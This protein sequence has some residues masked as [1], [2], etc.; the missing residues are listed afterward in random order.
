LGKGDGSFLP[1]VRYAAGT[2]PNS[3]AV[4]DFNRDQQPDLAIANDGGVSVLI[5]KSDGSFLPA[6]S[7]GAGRNP[8][9]V[10][11]GDFNADQQLD[12]AVAN[13][14]GISVLL[15][16]GDGSFQPAVTYRAGSS[17]SSV[18]LGD[19]NG[20]G[21]LDVSVANFGSARINFTDSSA[22]VLLG[23]GDG[24][25]QDNTN[26]NAGT[27]PSSVAVADFNGDGKADLAVANE[28]IAVFMGNGDGTFREAVNFA[29]S[30]SPWAVAVGDFNGDGKPDLVGANIDSANVSVLLNT[31]GAP[32]LDLA[33]V[34]NGD[35]LTVSWQ[36]PSTGFVLESIMALDAA[37]WQSAAEMPATNNGRLEVTVPIS[38]RE[39]YFRLHKP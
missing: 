5:G 10:A 15:G 25:F 12:L 2:S 8:S 9:A 20:D 26:F 39:R 24:T 36:F 21:N 14:G 29:V 32:G 4:G 38:Q 19:F 28:G 11:V 35:S 1:A 37:N 18:A 34:R 31:C 7:Y 16:N 22:S 30:S 17:P 23:R 27:T 3:V 13:D 33:I 6:V